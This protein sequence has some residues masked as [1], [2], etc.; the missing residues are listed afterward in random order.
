VRS[1]SKTGEENVSKN[2]I[3]FSPLQRTIC[4]Q[5]LNSVY[6][7]AN[8]ACG[9]CSFDKAGYRSVDSIDSSLLHDELHEAIFNEH[10]E[11]VYDRSFASCRSCKEWYVPNVRHSFQ[12]ILIPSEIA[13]PK[14][15]Y[16]ECLQLGYEDVCKYE[17]EIVVIRA[18]FEEIGALYGA[19]KQKM[20]S[21]KSRFPKAYYGLMD[22]Y[23][24]TCMS[25]LANVRTLKKAYE[26][27]LIPI[28]ERYISLD[29]VDEALR[30]WEM[31]LTNDPSNAYIH[32]RL[33]EL[34]E[35]CEKN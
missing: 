28:G 17:E 18:K 30:V 1:K 24:S 26:N 25:G 32:K 34:L 11:G 22:V 5:I 29:K 8:G 31:V 7:R 6:V 20:Q 9:L 3:D 23:M 4:Q 2:G 10:V 21:V 13:V 33:D 35:T 14:N 16:D 12:D 19:K 27:V 15:L